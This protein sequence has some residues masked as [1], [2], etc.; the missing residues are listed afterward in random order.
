MGG[1]SIGLCQEIIST[2]GQDGMLFQI[3]GGHGWKVALWI[4]RMDKHSPGP[5]A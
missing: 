4:M 1:F 5:S 3:C 2:R